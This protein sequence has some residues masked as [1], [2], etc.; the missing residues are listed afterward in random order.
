MNCVTS[1]T[2]RKKEKE[3]NMA[4]FTTKEQNLLLETVLKEHLGITLANNIA[5]LRSK[6]N[7]FANDDEIKVKMFNNKQGTTRVRV[8]KTEYTDDNGDTA[9]AYTPTL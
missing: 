7:I 5:D 4:E 2:F 9:Y 1:H 8:F 6:T 3:E